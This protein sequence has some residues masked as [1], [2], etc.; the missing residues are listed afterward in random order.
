MKFDSKCVLCN[1][2]IDF[3]FF[4]LFIWKMGSQHNRKSR[5]NHGENLW[6]KR[7][8]YIKFELQIT[9]LIIPLCFFIF[10]L[11]L[12][13]HVCT[14]PSVHNCPF[15]IPS[16]PALQGA[17]MSACP[18]PW[19]GTELGMCPLIKLWRVSADQSGHFFCQTW[20]ITSFQLPHFP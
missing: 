3:F 9:S 14:W 5:K 17:L 19:K 8:H 12:C 10:E 16:V 6:I 20:L 11:Y 1:Y 18:Q 4:V 2:L 13:I 15:V 7:K